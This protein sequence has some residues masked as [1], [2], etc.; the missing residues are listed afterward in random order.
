[1][2]LS[3]KKEVC[4]GIG[5]CVEACPVDCINKAQNKNAKGTDYF[6]IDFSTCID[7]GVCLEVCPI[8]GAVIAEERKDLQPDQ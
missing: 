1:M 4:E 7:C 2:T 3:I 5:L 6:Y 8:K